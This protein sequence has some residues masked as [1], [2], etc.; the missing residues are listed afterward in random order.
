MAIVTPKGARWE[1]NPGTLLLQALV[2]SKSYMAQASA[3]AV[4][5]TL[6]AIWLALDFL[7]AQIAYTVMKR[8]SNVSCLKYRMRYTSSSASSAH[9][10][11]FNR[12]ISDNIN[13]LLA[14]G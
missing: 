7:E 13:S 1:P 12:S 4:Q 9:M 14:E 8:A 11:Q 2:E 6:Y 10:A 3:V 5:T